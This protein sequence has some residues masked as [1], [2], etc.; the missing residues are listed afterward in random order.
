MDQSDI[1]IRTGRIK[2]GRVPSLDPDGGLR[3]QNFQNIY[4]FVVG[5]SFLSVVCELRPDR[6]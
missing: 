2:T 1:L 3:L 6:T 4:V 5:S